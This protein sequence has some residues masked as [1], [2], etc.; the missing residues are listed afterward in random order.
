M[1]KLLPLGIVEISAVDPAL[2]VRALMSD[3]RPTLEQGFGGWEEIERPRRTPITTWKSLPALHLTLPLLFDGFAAERSVEK[4]LGI[5]MQ[6]GRPVGAN[7]EPPL[8]RVKARGAA[9]PG[10]GRKWVL[11]DLAWGDALMNQKGERVR[12]QVTLALTEYIEDV[13]MQERSAANRRRSKHAASKTQ[14]GAKAKRVIAKRK[15]HKPGA[16][17]RAAAEMSTAGEDLLTIAARELG[18]ADRWVEIAQLNGLR[19][20][21]AIAPGQVLRMP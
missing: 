8:L 9:L 3:E 17:S 13:N 11:Q 18:D 5:L 20:P 19:D 7:G 1:A 6:M 15:P 21:R 4:Q 16:P 14:H 2:K 12:Q 10:Q